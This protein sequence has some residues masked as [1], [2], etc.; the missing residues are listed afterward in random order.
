MK[1][2]LVIF[3]AILIGSASS[4]LVL[5]GKWCSLSV[6]SIGQLQID[7]IIYHFL[8]TLL[9]AQ[10]GLQLIPLTI[11]TLRLLTGAMRTDS[12]SLSPPPV[13]PRIPKQAERPI[14]QLSD[15]L[16]KVSSIIE[17]QMNEPSPLPQL[18]DM[19]RNS[20]PQLGRS[21][22]RLLQMGLNLNDLIPGTIK[23]FRELLSSIASDLS[24]MMENPM[25]VVKVMYRAL[26]Y[27]DFDSLMR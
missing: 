12:N 26:G 17:N 10:A 2:N 15:S 24:S 19:S 20:L 18:T 25:N 4:Q 7:L 22:M 21:I 1:F 9:S 16:S 6:S 11:R 14:R 27:G 13:S 23:Y 8:G 3:F 5:L